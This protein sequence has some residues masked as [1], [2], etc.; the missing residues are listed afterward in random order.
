MIGERDLDFIIDSVQC[1]YLEDDDD[2]QG[3]W[4]IARDPEVPSIICILYQPYDD[5]SQDTYYPPKATRYRLTLLNEVEGDNAE[6]M[7][8]KWQERR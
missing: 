7:Y 6:N 1:D 4:K 5:R 8:E 3:S 2:V